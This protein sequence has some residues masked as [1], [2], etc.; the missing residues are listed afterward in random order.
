MR[1]LLSHFD[2]L[3]YLPINFDII[4]HFLNVFS[5]FGQFWNQK[6]SK[7][8]SQ[9]TVKLQI[10]LKDLPQYSKKD[11]EQVRIERG[12]TQRE[13]LD[14]MKRLEK[15]QNAKNELMKKE[16]ERKPKP[17]IKNAKLAKKYNFVQLRKK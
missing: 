14:R 16:D 3:D 12:K 15:L 5:H 7:K 6:I 9:I 4:S 1:L 11:Y 8:K 10:Y 2:V 17:E 13:L